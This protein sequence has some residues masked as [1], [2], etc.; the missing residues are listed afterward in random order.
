MGVTEYPCARCGQAQKVRAPNG[1]EVNTQK[2]CARCEEEVRAEEAAST[3]PGK[4]D[5]EKKEHPARAE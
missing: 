5:K 3:K 2:L 1:Q 4:G